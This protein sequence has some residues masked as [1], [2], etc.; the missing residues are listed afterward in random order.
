MS[1]HGMSCQGI[2]R[3][4]VYPWTDHSF[5]SFSRLKTKSVAAKSTHTAIFMIWEPWNQFFANEQSYYVVLLSHHTECFFWTCKIVSHKVVDYWTVVCCL[6]NSSFSRVYYRWRPHQM[7][8]VLKKNRFFAQMFL[9]V[10][11]F[12][13]K[14]YKLNPVWSCTNSRVVIMSYGLF[15]V[16]LGF[17]KSLSWV[18]KPY[19]SKSWSYICHQTISDIKICDN[20]SIV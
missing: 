20:K 3:K 10:S 4:T 13:L 8:N 14:S 18:V 15:H 12:V 19:K 5:N 9:L 1:Y 6:F 17:G 2:K 16:L 7:W 11:V